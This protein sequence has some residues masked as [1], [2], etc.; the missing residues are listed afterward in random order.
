MTSGDI[1][2]SRKNKGNQVFKNGGGWIYRQK[3]MRETLA[4]LRDSVWNMKSS[5]DIISVAKAIKEGLTRHGV[6]YNF[7]GINIVDDIDN[8]REVLVYNFFEEIPW[9][10]TAP[11]KGREIIL[12]IW[13]E[14][15]TV[16][17][18]DIA[19]VDALDESI[20]FDILF[21][22]SVRSVIDVPFSHGTLAVSS[23][24]PNSFSETDIVVLE[25]MA[26]VLTDVF[27]RS[28]DLRRL[29][30]YTKQLEHEISEH[31]KSECAVRES[32]ARYR[33]LVEGSPD[34]IY[35]F[36]SKRG[37]LFWS[38]RVKQ[39]LGY[40]PQQILDDP[41]LWN[42][43]IHPDDSERVKES[44]TNDAHDVVY[45]IRDIDGQWHWFQDRF[46]GKTVFGDEVIVE[47]LAS[48]I[49]EQRNAVEELR[50]SEILYRSTINAMS[51]MIHVVDRDLRVILHNDELRKR[52]EKDSFSPS[53]TGKTLHEL[54]PFIPTHVFDE[55]R[56]VIEEKIPFKSV[57]TLEING[58][59]IILEAHKIPIIENGEV[60]RIVTIIRDV[61]ESRLMLEKLNES[62]ERYRLLAE[63][64]PVGIITIDRDGT[65]KD[66]NRKLLE[67]LGSK[68][69]ETTKEINILKFPLLVESG[70]SADFEKCLNGGSVIVNSRQYTSLWGK[71][72]FLRYTLSPMIDDNTIVGVQGIIEDISEQKR[73]E[74]QVQ[75]RQHMDSLG[76]IAGGI[77]HD[78][79][80]LLAG[81]MGNLDYLMLDKNS[82][83]DHHLESIN[84]AYS[85]CKRAAKLI[86]DFQTVTD[87][88]YTEKTCVDLYGIATEVFGI[89]RRTTD[90]VITKTVDFSEGQYFV[91]GNTGQLHQV[92]MNLGTNAAQAIEAKGPGAEDQISVSAEDYTI[93][94]N[95]PT[96]LPEGSYVHV[97]FKDTGTGMPEDVKRRVF[98]PLFTTKA[99]STRKGQGLGLAMVYTI[100][101]RNH[102]GRI[103]VESEAGKGTTF[104]IYLPK[105]HC[106]AI[107]EETAPETP[108]KGSGTILVVEDEDSIRRLARRI[109]VKLG[110]DVLEAVD[111]EEGL[112]LFLLN[113]NDIDLVLLDLNIP[114]MSGGELMERI[115]DVKPDMKIVISSGHS[116][117]EIRKYEK[118]S[119]YISKPYSITA[120]SQIL[121]SVMKGE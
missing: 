34:I 61:T 104:H 95:G 10:T 70:I 117:A 21:N 81:I 120:L 78:F 18:R 17:R 103:G 115:H 41:F 39:L 72:S 3:L 86:G 20:N 48:D 36:S 110:F 56:R 13:K 49:T 99:R 92:F 67:I 27:R 12:S 74:E 22:S 55:Y 11:E 57:D 5:D 98:E 79:N 118:A 82:F 102:N 77:A 54:Y 6:T 68:S 44:M 114:K 119:G 32:E 25:N 1:N 107:V 26:D 88:T 53:I 37:A 85:T 30:N 38:G 62:E 91:T 101:T 15:K 52:N 65:T 31:E 94:A 16:Y 7:C 75:V 64:S 35:I 96:G 71:K 2:T 45:R 33:R 66:V 23:K 47:G 8:P 43:S 24:K 121:E 76:D 40:S 106:Q 28:S 59:T 112:D 109:L 111:G 63:N 108:V 100:I 84:E 89:L 69:L 60:V 116:D 113:Q 42:R 50:N 73:L 51:D 9:T 46:I 4:M 87:Y 90:R 80:N 58:N 19:D 105:A 93:N 97:M 14:G 29:E 83:A